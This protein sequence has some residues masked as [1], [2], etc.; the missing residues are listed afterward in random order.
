MPALRVQRTSKDAN[1]LLPIFLR[2]HILHQVLKTKEGALLRVLFVWRR[3]VSIG[4]TGVAC[5]MTL[6]EALAS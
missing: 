4:S 3:S 2:M 1:R 5:A 6:L